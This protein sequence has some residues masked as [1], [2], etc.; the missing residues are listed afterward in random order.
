MYLRS[1]LLIYS[2]GSGVNRVKAVLSGFSM[3][4]FCYV[5]EKTFMYVWL[6][7]FPDCTRACVC[8]C[9]GDVI[10]VGHDLNRCTGCW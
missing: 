10:C 8:G 5:Q 3:R 1:R 4:L 9:D 2:A 7:I 6:Y